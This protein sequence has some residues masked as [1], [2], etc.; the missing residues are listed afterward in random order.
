M[1]GAGM[2]GD[3]DHE[4]TYASVEDRPGILRERLW[5]TIIMDAG[6]ESERP[7]DVFA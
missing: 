1:V 2:L 7:T 5:M 3:V 6:V 4:L